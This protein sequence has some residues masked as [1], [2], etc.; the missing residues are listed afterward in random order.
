MTFS[1]AAQ[2]A[3]CSLDGSS[4]QSQAPDILLPEE[5]GKVMSKPRNQNITTLH[6]VGEVKPW[7]HFVAGG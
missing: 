2:G 3:H 1:S 6:K 5:T 4:S 7:A